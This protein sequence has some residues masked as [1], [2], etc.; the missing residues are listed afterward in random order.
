MPWQ[1]CELAYVTNSSPEGKGLSG[2]VPM[3]CLPSEMLAFCALEVAPLGRLGLA[4]FCQKGHS[5]AVK[6]C[7]IH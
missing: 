2:V 4:P 7:C 5:N 1:D 6:Y 3:A